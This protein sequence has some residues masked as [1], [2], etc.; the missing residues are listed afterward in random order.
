MRQPPVPFVYKAVIALLGP[1]ATLMTRKTWRGRENLP[2][3]GGFVV[4]ANHI[5]NLDFLAVMKLL[6]WWARPPQVLAKES[7]FHKPILGA[8]MRGMGMIPVR[9]GT[10]QAA[11]ALDGALKA[12]QQGGLVLV[13][14]EGTVTRDPNLWPMRGRPGAVKMAL[15]AGCPLIPVAQW[16][17]QKILPYRTKKFRPFPPTRVFLQVGPAIDLNDLAK[18]ADKDAA[19]REGTERLM[20]SIT[21]MLGELR[22]LTP[23]AEPFNQFAAQEA[24]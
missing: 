12:I 20:R 2:A 3:T 18:W 14:P 10:A 16:G 9:R 19:A 1:I 6:I 7:L 24:S 4:A 15:E 22:G 11:G 17:A 23:P 8:A 21:Q 13:Y 5:S